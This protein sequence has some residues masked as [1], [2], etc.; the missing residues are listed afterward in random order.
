MI[1]K[2]CVVL[3]A[4]A[5][6]L[7][8]LFVVASVTAGESV[9]IS[10]QSADFQA[11]AA[12][13]LLILGPVERVDASTAR[14]QILGQWIPLSQ[15]SRNLEELV[16]H[17]LSVYG[18]V[19]ADGTFDV[20]S[21]KE[22]QSTEYVPGSTRLYL[23][24]SVAALDVVG[25]NAQVGSLSVNYTNAL[26]TLVASDLFVG[27]VVSFS[28]VQFAGAT[29]LYADNGLIHVSTN[30]ALAGQTGS[31]SA[32]TLAGQTGSGSAVKLAGQTGSGSA[33]TLAGQTGSGSE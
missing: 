27:A 10:G 15:N 6:V 2:G 20:A 32:T 18:S 3:R 30:V 31:G 19:A 4:C 24:G 16:G 1:S 21:V 9:S 13:N 33:T 25:G 29:K 28:G 14:A 8:A 17:V 23:K 5:T 7:C 11:L 22:Q 26:H 12:S